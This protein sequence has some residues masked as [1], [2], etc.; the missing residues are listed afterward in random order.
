MS[1]RSDRP[2]RI[3][4]AR[5]VALDVLAKPPAISRLVR[6]APVG[7]LI[8]SWQLP[9]H[10]CPGINALAELSPRTRGSLK[11]EALQ[12]MLEQSLFRR[13]KEPLPGRPQVLAVRLSSVEP[14]EHSGWSK[15]PV[16]RLCVGVRKRP[17][18]TPEA[19]WKQICTKAGPVGLGWLR[20]DRPA[21]VDLKTWWEPA[22]P[23]EGCVY[24]ELRTG[25][26]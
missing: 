9:L 20:D 11:A 6:P 8:C 2:F 18:G 17:K 7:D 12:I 24:I 5:A 4:V 21:D 3:A 14:D 19:I 16:D 22:P 1:E 10:L 26:S 23:G 15:I 13:A 25:E